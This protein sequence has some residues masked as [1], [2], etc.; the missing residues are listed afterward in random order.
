MQVFQYLFQCFKAAVVNLIISD[1]GQKKSK[2]Y[3]LPAYSLQTKI[4]SQNNLSSFAARLYIRP[5]MGHHVS[6]IIR[7][8]ELWR[9]QLEMGRMN[10]NS[11]PSPLQIKHS[12][13]EF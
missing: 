8:V 4:L 12:I 2:Y 9:I 13:T 1:Q 10:I 7:V 5:S 11:P 6:P 3:H